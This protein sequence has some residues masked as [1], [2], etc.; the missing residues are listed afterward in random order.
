MTR[1]E[2]R[3]LRIENRIIRCAAVLL[4]SIAVALTLCCAGCTPLGKT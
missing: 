1:P 4:L 3:T 2:G